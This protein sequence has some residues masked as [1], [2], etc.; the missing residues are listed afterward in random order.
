M[1]LKLQNGQAEGLNSGER[2]LHVLH[3]DDGEDRTDKQPMDVSML[4]Y[5]LTLTSELKCLA[6]QAGHDRLGLML[7]LA[8]EEARQKLGTRR[9]R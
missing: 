7:L 3:N 5:I 6:R 8:E 9:T 1:S 4:E 2:V